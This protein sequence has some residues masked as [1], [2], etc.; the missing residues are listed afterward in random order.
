MD[1]DGE[2]GKQE[3]CL[4]RK[5]SFA[6]VLVEQKVLLQLRVTT[7]RNQISRLHSGTYYKSTEKYLR[8]VEVMLCFEL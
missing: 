8:I 7:C 5:A 6:L 4:G 2:V 3:M 1:K